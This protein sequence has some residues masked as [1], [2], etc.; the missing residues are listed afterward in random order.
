MKANKLDTGF[1]L[2]GNKGALWGN[3]AHIAEV[4]R[5]GTL[6]GTPMLAT[7]WCRIENVEDIGCVKCLKAYWRKKG[8]I[9]LNSVGTFVNIKTKETYAE[10]TNGT[11]YHSI[12]D[13]TPLSEVS[14]EWIDRLSNEDI[15]TLWSQFA[16]DVDH[17]VPTQVKN[18]L[19][20]G[21]DNGSYLE[22]RRIDLKLREIGWSIEHGLNPD[23]VLLFKTIN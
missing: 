16:D 2:Y 15:N 7:N 6:C 23:E 21:T 18:I 5:S 3:K 4:N 1:Y 12:I 8:W 10:L 9:Y 14:Q 11:P 22:L 19:S 13:G 17:I 20:S